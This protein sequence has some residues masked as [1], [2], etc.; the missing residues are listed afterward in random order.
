MLDFSVT[1]SSAAVPP[2]RRSQ[3]IANPRFGRVFTDHMVSVDWKAGR[4]WHDGRLEPYAPLVLDPATAVFHYGQEVLE[5]LKAYR[6]PD[7]ALALF[8]PR[9]NA[10]RFQKSC[11]R[12]A[13]PPVPEELFISAIELLVSTD[14]DWLPDG[15]GSSLYLR[16]FMISTDPR[17]DLHGPGDTYRFMVIASPA[18]GPLRQPVSVWLSEDYVRAAPGGTGAV[19][20]GGNYGAAIAAEVQALANGCDQVVWLDAVDHRQVE[21]LGG[22]NLFFVYGGAPEPRLLTPALTGTL[23]PGVTRDSLLALAPALGLHA[24]EATIAVS[25]WRAAAQSGE[26]TEVFACGTAAAVLPV[27]RVKGRTD[28]WV[29]GGGRTGPVTRRLREELLGIQQGLRP[30]PYGWVHRIA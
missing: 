11:L 2:A 8:R 26:L 7:G 13:M 24:A 23:L 17:L 10:A 18:V 19:K 12:M 16:P 9:E 29:I 15:Q 3:L 25:D 14:R 6:Q 21:E 20:C 22:M 30:D 4:G 27:G 5:G 1:A 28:D